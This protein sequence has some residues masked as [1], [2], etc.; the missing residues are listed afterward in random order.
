MRRTVIIGPPPTPNGDLHVGHVAG[1][2]LAADVY[3]RWLRATG[4]PVLYAS[5]TD[6]SQTYV[7]ASAAKLGTTPGEL[8]ERSW[9]AIEA[10]LRAMGVT[11]DGFAPFDEHYRAMVLDFA[12]RLYR[13][14]RFELR[15]VR[16]PWSVRNEQFLVEGLVSG[17]CPVCLAVSRGGLCETCGHPNNCAELIDPRSTIDPDDDVVTRPASILVL[18]LER[19]RGQLTAYYESRQSAWRP[20]IVQLMRELLA[21]PLP[22]F[23]ITYPT[24][25]GIPAPFQ[26]TPGQVF[27]A[28]FEGMPASMYCTEVAQREHGENPSGT[29]EEWL[30]GSGIR[31]VY[32]LGFDNAY[33]WGVT[34]LAALMAHDG[35][36]ALPDVIVSNEF[37]ELENEKFSTSKGHVVWA[38]DLVSEV[39]RDLVRFYLALTAPE[40]ARTNFSR[41]ALDTITASRLVQPWN[42]LAGALNKAVAELGVQGRELP[43]SAD[44]ARRRATMT[45]R[46]AACYELESFSLT[47]AADLV[48]LHVARLAD[49]AN[50]VDF[51][52]ADFRNADTGGTGGTGAAAREQALGDLYAETAGLV[53][54]ASPV[55]VDLADA[56]AAA[57][58][59]LDATAGADTATTVRP[60][61][62]PLLDSD[63][64]RRR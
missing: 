22:D 59:V 8:A 63:H 58:A 57:G 64:E 10:T 19:Y 56:A 41:A 29:D 15:T 21:R 61:T 14:G 43:V 47:R 33:F 3:A 39:P 7:V 44:A 50:T 16:L 45:E 42:V 9:H 37:Y 6:D 62:V 36:Y 20:H 49:A 24:P 27:N 13:A 1:P 23:P 46:F 2:Y 55:L 40:Y 38:R 51:T 48:A 31:L 30:A 5:G 53:L 11:V 17:G 18:P 34:H 4:R 35:R 25:W 60:F 12:D 54:A 28:W 26:E 32:F 52:A